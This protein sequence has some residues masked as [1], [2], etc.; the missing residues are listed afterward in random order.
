MMK[1]KVITLLVAATLTGGCN[2]H[3][4]NPQ[5]ADGNS[6]CCNENKTARLTREEIKARSFDELFDSIDVK[7]IREDVFT[8]VGENYGILTAGTAE[9]F[10]SMVTSWGGWGIVF[11][12]PGVFHFLRSKDT[13][14]S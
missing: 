6:A 2:S 3:S 4:G 13:H 5:Q 12:K 14:W 8:L 10:N 1:L 9:K 7:G 11:G